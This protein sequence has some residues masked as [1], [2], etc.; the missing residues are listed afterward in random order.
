M[1]LRTYASYTYRSRNPLKRLAHNSRFELAARFVAGDVLDYGCGDGHFSRLAAH[2]ARFTNYEPLAA[3][4]PTDG[5]PCVTTLQG[6]DRRFDCIACL[7]VLEHVGDDKQDEFFADVRRL[8]APDGRVII[9]V[10]VMIGP[11]GFF[12]IAMY[13]GRGGGYTLG[14]A[15]RHLFGII[16]QR[17]HARKDGLYE[18][19][20]FDHRKL[21]QR[22]RAEF[23]VVE[24]HCSPFGPLPAWMNSQVF[25]V[26][27]GPTASRAP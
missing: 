14:A 16:P 10:P 15:L 12:K 25:F 26:C 27:R 20:G 2:R 3:N 17:R 18:H 5:T 6:L 13:L 8:L 1:P 22:L 24:E 4:A 21:R 23:N 7:E 11:I 19:E 9:S